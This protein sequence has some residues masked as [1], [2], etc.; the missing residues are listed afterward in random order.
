MAKMTTG[1]AKALKEVVG[2]K[3]VVTTAVGT[4]Q[5]VGVEFQKAAAELKALGAP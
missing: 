2:S 3:A 1:V 5:R 4:L